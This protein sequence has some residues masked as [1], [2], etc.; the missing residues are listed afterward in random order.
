M[1]KFILLR[2]THTTI[3]LTTVPKVQGL[4]EWRQK[5]GN[6]FNIK[7]IKLKTSIKSNNWKKNTFI[8][9][10]SDITNYTK[11]LQFKK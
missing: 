9:F 5:L 8:K 4:L 1:A 6:R 11:E 2:L 3:I 10:L 7:I